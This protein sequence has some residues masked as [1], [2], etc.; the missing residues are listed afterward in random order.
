MTPDHLNPQHHSFD[1]R[2]Y[3]RWIWSQILPGQAFLA[4]IGA[5]FALPAAVLLAVALHG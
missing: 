2:A 5:A 4:L 3:R 1:R